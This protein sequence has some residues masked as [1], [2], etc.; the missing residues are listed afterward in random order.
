MSFR[1]AALLLLYPEV[2]PEE[3]L[4]FEPLHKVLLLMRVRNSRSSYARHREK[5]TENMKRFLNKKR[6]AILYKN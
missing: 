2:G 5:R 1:M 3:R 4:R 6:A